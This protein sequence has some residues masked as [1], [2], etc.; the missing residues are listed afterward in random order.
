MGV[1]IFSI[2][3]SGGY[4]PVCNE[5]GIY[6]FWGINEQDYFDRKEFWNSWICKECK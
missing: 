3:I 6:L 2:T 4:T 5:C 1:V